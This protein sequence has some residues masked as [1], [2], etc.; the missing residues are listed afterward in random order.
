MEQYQEVSVVFLERHDNVWR[1]GQI[2]RHEQADVYGIWKGQNEQWRE[3]EPVHMY[4]IMPGSLSPGDWYYWP[5]KQVVRKYTEYTNSDTTLIKVIAAYPGGIVEDKFPTVDEL[6]VKEWISNQGKCKVMMERDI[7]QYDDKPKLSDGCILLKIVPE[8]VGYMDSQIESAAEQCAAPF[9][10]P[11]Q[12]TEYAFKQGAKFYEEQLLLAKKSEGLK[13]NIC[14]K[15][16]TEE[17]TLNLS[18]YDFSLTCAEHNYLRNTFQTNIAQAIAGIN[19]HGFSDADIE[20]FKSNF[21][22]NDKVLSW[23]MSIKSTGEKLMWSIDDLIL[24]R[25]GEE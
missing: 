11:F 25:K 9:Y 13:C 14:D 23:L 6:F 22:N 15:Q 17:E 1:E 20:Q 5:D 3:W 2:M 10:L 19:K 18:A 4:I 8:P 21:Q 16:L 24:R 12:N 7:K